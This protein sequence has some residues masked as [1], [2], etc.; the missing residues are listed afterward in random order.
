MALKSCPIWST[1]KRVT[2]INRFVHPLAIAIESGRIPMIVRVPDSS[3][4]ICTILNAA[5]L[6][7]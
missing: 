4:L 7:L 6:R 5:C 2:E 1:Y 3:P